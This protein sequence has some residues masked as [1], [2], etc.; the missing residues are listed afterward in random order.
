MGTGSFDI[1]P[2]A[3][4]GKAVTPTSR[5]VTLTSS[6]PGTSAQNFTL[7]SSGGAI[8]PVRANIMVCGSPQRPVS[9]FL[10]AGY[11]LQVVNGCAPDSNTQA[12]FMTRNAYNS[13]LG[14]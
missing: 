13:I 8:G 5:T 2:T 14:S 10:P 9:N 11:S 7:A 3:P 1:K 12:L 4:A 6:V